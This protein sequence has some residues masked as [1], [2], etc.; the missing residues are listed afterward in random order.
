MS[1]ITGD[2]GSFSSGNT[3]EEVQ[4]LQEKKQL[5][6]E[7]HLHGSGLVPSGAMTNS[8]GSSSQQQ[9]A[10]KKR[11]LPGTPGNFNNPM[12]LNYICFHNTNLCLMGMYS[13]K[14]KQQLRMKY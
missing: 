12:N 10:K 3:G 6:L 8:N 13:K 7:N 5:Q 1:N 4:Q 9:P 14:I 2:E 11:N